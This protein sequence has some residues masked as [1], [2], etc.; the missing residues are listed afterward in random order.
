MTVV[1]PRNT[2]IPVLRETVFTTYFDNQLGMLIKIYEGER[3]RTRDNILVTIFELDGI[4]PA[5][6]GVPQIRVRF[7]LNTDNKLY[8]SA[9]D[10][11]SGKKWKIFSEDNERIFECDGT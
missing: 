4:P 2:T 6:R 1:V 10:K 8:V 5:P 7:D 3:A 9:T 11:H